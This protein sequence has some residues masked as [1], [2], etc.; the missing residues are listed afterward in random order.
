MAARAEALAEPIRQRV[1]P[2]KPPAPPASQFTPNRRRDIARASADLL[3][4][5]ESLR[6]LFDG[7]HLQVVNGQHGLNVAR[8]PKSRASNTCA[9]VAS[10]S[11]R[12]ARS[13]CT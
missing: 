6:A 4:N 3:G 5:F 9:R 11:E 2:P 12:M 8:G 7:F 10:I 1:Q 13:F